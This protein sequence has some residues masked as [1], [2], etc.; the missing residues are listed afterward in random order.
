VEIIEMSIF[1]SDEAY[2][3]AYEEIERK[4]AKGDSTIETTGDEEQ[5]IKEQGK[6]YYINIINH[7]H[8]H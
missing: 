5:M 1:N 2:A 8:I 3:A 6:I 7:V 4:I